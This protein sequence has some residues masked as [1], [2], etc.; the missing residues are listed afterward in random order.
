MFSITKCGLNLILLGLLYIIIPVIAIYENEAGTYDWHHK[1]V[2]HPREAFKIDDNHIAVYS[3]Q[4]VIA[5]LEINNGAIEWRQVLENELDHVVAS[6]A[7]IFTV[8][9]NP[10]RAQFW[11]KTNGQLMWEY[12]LPKEEYFGSTSPVILN[13][14]QVAVFVGRTKLIK[15]SNNGEEVWHWTRK[16]NP[17]QIWERLKLIHRG[18]SIY[19]IVEPDDNEESPFFVIHTIDSETGDATSTTKIP[20]TTTYEAISYIGDYLFWTENDLLKWTNIDK[21]DIKS[22]SIKSLVSLL[23]TADKFVPSRISLLGNS[24]DPKF[25]SFILTAEYE[26]EEESRTTSASVLVYI[27][28][29]ALSLGTYFGEQESFVSFDTFKNLIAYTVRSTPKESIVHLS[30]EAKDIKIQHDVTLSGEINYIKLV[31]LEPFRLFVVTEGSSVFLYNESSIVWSREESL[32]AITDSKFLDLPEQKMW[33]QMAD[34]L[35]ETTIEQAAEKP[36]SRYVRRLTTHTLALRKLPNWI[37]SHF[38]GMTSSTLKDNSN[39]ISNLEAQ[40]CWLNETQ[41]ELLYRDNF[42]LRKLLISVTKSGKIIAQ[43]TTHNGKIVW[44]RYIENFSFNELHIVRAASIKMPPIIVAIGSTYDALGGEATGFVRLNALTGD[45]YISTIHEAAEFFEPIILTNIGVDK[46][47]RLPIEDPEERTHIL[48]IYEAG[49]GRV[50]IYP[51]THAA[52]QRFTNEF[53]PNYYFSYK[54]S[55]GNMQG[56]KVTEGYRGSL[57]ANPL[58]NFYLPENESPVTL[59]HSQ[60]YEKVASLGRALGNRNVLYKYLNPHMFAMVTKDNE[61]KYIKIRIMDSIKGS[62]LHETIHEN[63]DI[64]NNDVHILQSE[65]WFVYHFWS[66]DIKGRGYRTVVLELFEGAHENM[67]IESTNFSSFDNVQPHVLSSSFA[68]PYPIT[69]MGVTTTRNGI[70]TKNIL[71]GLLSHQIMAVNKR[72]FDPRRPTEKPTKEDQ[73][74]QLF[75]YGPI[76][77]DK[78]LFLTYGLDVAGIQTIITSPSLLES[79]SLVFAYGLDTFFTRSSPSRQFD[80]LSEDFSKVQ[81][82]LTIIGLIVGIWITGP[83]VRRKRVNALWK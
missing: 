45:N 2:G 26:E 10:E 34:E 5:A 61:K 68:F 14:G 18:N 64:E 82:L 52:R 39:K 65:N 55:H 23:P 46:V 50:Y 75:P 16:T 24:E 22:T 1:W 57:R 12:T 83:M 19:I 21:I 11:N 17:D 28:D 56:F 77:D 67:R 33:T 79:T 60:P 53:L 47:M 70:S 80:V 32:S 66:N 44:S 76:P 25:K 43:D 42:G 3:E 7:G 6:E 31:N 78:R 72:L 62:I 73:E 41:P 37:I 74:E 69:T 4:N 15:L 9:S 27:K 36:L 59:S 30:S 63:V 38:V 40:S 13:D 54:D 20:C 81:L 71:F 29:E 35:D 58:W 49:S 8:S 51:D 48:A